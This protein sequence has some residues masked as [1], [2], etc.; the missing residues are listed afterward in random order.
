MLKDIGTF[1]AANTSLTKGTTLQIYSYLQTAPERAV[2]IANLSGGKLYQTVRDRVDYALQ[3]M[4]RAEN[5]THAHDD[6]LEMHA[7]LFESGTSQRSL[8]IGSPT[9]RIESIQPVGYPQCVGKDEK[10]RYVYVCN[11]VLK[12]WRL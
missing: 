4:S 3:V 9:F 5:P 12:I 11:Y 8:P 1:I 2:K 6:I 7:F 10:G